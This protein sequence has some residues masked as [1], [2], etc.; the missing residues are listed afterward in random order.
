M[1]PILSLAPYLQLMRLDKPVGIWLLLLPCWWGLVL[2]GILSDRVWDTQSYFFAAWL[3]VLFSAGAV[4]MRAAGCIINDFWDRDIDAKVERTRGRPLASGAISKMQAFLL[5]CLLLLVG[6]LVLLQ[7]NVL[8]IALGILSLGL[9]VTYPLMKRVTWWPQA[10][11]GVTFNWGI[12]MGAAAVAGELKWQVILLY[13]TAIFWTLSYD[14]IYA[15]QDIEDDA[16]IGVKST[17]LRFKA[18]AKRF[19]ALCNALFVFGLYCVGA[20]AHLSW[21]YFFGVAAV[22]LHLLWQMAYWKPAKPQNCLMMFRA[23]VMIGLIVFAAFL[24]AVFKF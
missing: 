14:T 17:A 2:G 22:A 18:H 10:F 21:L 24:V 20:F 5:L 8:A 16:R 4:V 15:H 3:F 12:L 9:V 11:L 23:N 1:R 6:L 13:F 19:V 7:L